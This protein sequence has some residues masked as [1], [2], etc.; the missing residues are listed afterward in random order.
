MKKEEIIIGLVLLGVLIYSY[1]KNMC[2]E[3]KEGFWWY[4]PCIYNAQNKMMCNPSFRPYYWFWNEPTRYQ[5]TLDL[6]G[7]AES[8]PYLLEYGGYAV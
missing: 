4:S 2:N 6:R 7:E 5:S 8:W 3:K 1:Y